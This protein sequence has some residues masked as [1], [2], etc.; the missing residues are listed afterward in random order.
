LAAYWATESPTIYWDRMAIGA[1]IDNYYKH[2]VS[3]VCA[4]Q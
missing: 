1:L 4:L 2:A 3:Y